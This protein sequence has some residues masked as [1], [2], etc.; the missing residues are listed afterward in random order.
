[1]ELSRRDAL[2][3]LAGVGSAALA[4][5]G[6]TDPTAEPASDLP[7][8]GLVA[9]AETVY[10]SA[11]SG[12]REFVGTY[13]RGRA[14]GRPAYRD[15][16]TATATEL[17]ERAVEWY[18]DPLPAL[19]RGDRDALLREVGAETAEPRR[20]GTLA[21]RTRLYLVN[22]LLYALYTSPTGGELVGT[23]NPPGHPGGTASYHR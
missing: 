11:V 14:E 6:G 3:A 21:E 4:G 18:D 1:M 19:S 23:T 22:D 2:A 17:D 13:V 8:D 9:V 16:L 15:A 7:L 20:E 10:P 12:H 5:C